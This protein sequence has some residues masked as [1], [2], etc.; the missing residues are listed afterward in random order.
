MDYYG[1]FSLTYK[2]QWKYTLK[3]T[4]NK[5]KSNGATSFYIISISYNKYKNIK[6]KV[7]FH[8]S[9]KLLLFKIK[10]HATGGFYIFIIHKPNI[11]QVYI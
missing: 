8:I 4:W 2:K 1:L 10:K 6:N 9:G 3:L 5:V 11:Y 7:I